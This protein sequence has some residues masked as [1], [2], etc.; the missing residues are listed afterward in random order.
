MR[1]SLPFLAGYLVSYIFRSINALLGPRLALE[2]GLTAGQLGLL[3]A[4]YF[5]ASIV[6]QLPLGMMLD[7][8]GPRRVN[9]ALF[10]L[11]VL[12]ALVF[13]SAKTYEVLVL[14]RALIGLGVAAALMSAMHAFVLWN[15]RE[16]IGMLIAVVYA[17]GG[18]GI[19][20]TSFPLAYALGVFTWREIFVG[21]A[22]VALAVVAVL[23][24]WVPERMAPKR[25]ESLQA[26]LAGLAEI[27]RDPG[28][29]RATLV[30]AANQFAVIPLLNLWMATWLRDVAGFAEG[31]VAWMLALVALAMIGGYLVF[32]RIGDALV[33]RG[34]TEFPAY[35]AALASTLAALAPLA[36][37][38]T[39]G[40]V[41]LWP[42]FI[43]F[44]M[45]AS[46]AFAI[47]NRR[48]PPE[49]AG[50]VNTVLNFV[51]LLAM[52]SGQWLIGGVLGLWPETAAGGYD[53]RGYMV[54]LGVQWMVLAAAL[55]WLWS[56]RELFRE[57]G[58]SRRR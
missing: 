20:V 54:A 5:A 9:A 4:S 39:H 56:G 17:T 18:L 29:R 42:L 41:L 48:F 45:G 37:G 33:R 51:A 24:L 21:L 6:I 55:A 13:A 43:F 23:A 11:T 52:F 25:P 34:G 7:R 27:V 50:R 40:A 19:L 46:L 36:L 31:A 38:V 57:P 14:G 30:L 22:G 1:V 2:F 26:Q 49:Y 12:G 32:G 47:A 28:V 8:Y 58:R 10:V 15:P 44:G 3:T 53:P 35:V 16:K